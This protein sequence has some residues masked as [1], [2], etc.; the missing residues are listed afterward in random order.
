MDRTCSEPSRRVLRRREA[1]GRPVGLWDRE[2]RGRVVRWLARARRLINRAA[3]LSVRPWVALAGAHASS[4]RWAVG[5]VAPPRLAARAKGR[6]RGRL[7][8]TE[9]RSSVD[10]R[11]FSSLSETDLSF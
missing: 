1:T 8:G 9:H 5:R 7:A 3:R 10:Q 6:G 4:L 2:W 11:H